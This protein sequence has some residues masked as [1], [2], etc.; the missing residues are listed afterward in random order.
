MQPT[1][2]N[3]INRSNSSESNSEASP[4]LPKLTKTTVATPEQVMKM[5]LNKLTPYEQQ[6]IYS[7]PQVYFIGANAKKRPGI[8]GGSNNCGYDDENGSYNHVA[9]DHVAFRYEVLKIIGKGSFGQVVKAYDHKNHQHV[10]LKIVRNEKRFHRQAQEEIKILEH[11]RKQKQ[12]FGR[13]YCRLAS[14]NP[15]MSFLGDEY[16]DFDEHTGFGTSLP[17]PQ[18]QR[19]HVFLLL[20]FWKLALEGVGGPNVVMELR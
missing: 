17:P 6:E 5:Y 12:F 3:G 19:K 18:K 7:Y 13:H 16:D 15:G 4:S 9:H 10:A 2:T 8:L 1:E 11:L 14:S 20:L